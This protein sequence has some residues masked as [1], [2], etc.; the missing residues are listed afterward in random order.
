MLKRVLRVALT[1][2]A[3]AT[4]SSWA[5]AQSEIKAHIMDEHVVQKL[6]TSLDHTSMVE[7]PDVVTAAVVGTEG[8]KMEF[9][10]NVVILEPQ[11]AGIQT[12]L[13]VWA[14]GKQLVY[15]VQPASPTSE[16]PFVIRETFAPP[17]PPPTGP[18]T[19]EATELRD[20][21]HG[22]FL[23]SMRSITVCKE[24][25]N[26]KGVHM[27]AVQVGEDKYAYYVR[28]TAVN[29]TKRSYRIVTPSVSHIIP[30]FGA[31]ITVKS[32]NQQLTPKQF[33]QIRLYDS[34]AVA[35]HGSTL[36][37][38]DLE[39]KEAV[40]WVMAVSKAG[41]PVGIYQ[42]SLPPDGKKRV[43]AAVVF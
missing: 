22:E 24:T 12:N 26:E 30:A 38:R 8:V 35:S 4:H 7:F 19:V 40:T 3:A 20:A 11:K 17:P 9:R 33:S 29:R 16:L 41:H 23:L 14:A 37:S 34:V 43:Q 42:F 25:Q 39:P 5:C 27:W 13:L 6:A 32:V 31:K 1:V 21:A 10:D 15:E 2:V 18:A 28:M 36:T